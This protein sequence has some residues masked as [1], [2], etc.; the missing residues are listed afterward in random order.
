VERKPHINI[1]D[2]SLFHANQKDRGLAADRRSP[3]AAA[4]DRAGDADLRENAGKQEHY[5]GSGS[6]RLD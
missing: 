2:W 4:A 6:Q 1:T 3:L 5:A